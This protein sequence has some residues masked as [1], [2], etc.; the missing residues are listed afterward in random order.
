M[1]ANALLVMLVAC[2]GCR[3]EADVGSA[4][5]IRDLPSAAEPLGGQARDPAAEDI[6]SSR[7]QAD[8]YP[9]E[10]GTPLRPAPGGS[11]E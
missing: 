11:D 4:D 9:V 8:P 6:P 7:E 2:A 3:P 1:R 10:P 5:D